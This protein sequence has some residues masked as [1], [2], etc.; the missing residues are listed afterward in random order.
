MPGVFAVG[1]VRHASV[2]GLAAA[3]GEGV[4]AMRLTSTQ[5]TLGDRAA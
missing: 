1:D 2:K 4:T 5:D 3:M